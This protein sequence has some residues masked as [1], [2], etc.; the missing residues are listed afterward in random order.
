MEQ[1]KKKKKFR[2][3]LAVGLGLVVFTAV[4]FFVFGGP[5]PMTPDPTRGCRADTGKARKG[6]DRFFAYTHKK[7]VYI[8]H[9]HKK[10]RVR[11]KDAHKGSVKALA[12]SLDSKTMATAGG[13]NVI[14]LWD[15]G[16]LGNWVFR[17]PEKIAELTGNAY[18]VKAMAF[19]KDGKQLVVVGEDGETVDVWD[20]A[21]KQLLEN[22]LGLSAPAR[23][24]LLTVSFDNQGRVKDVGMEKA[25]LAYSK[26][27]LSGVERQGMDAPQILRDT[28]SGRKINT[29]EKA[30]TETWSSGGRYRGYADGDQVLI[31]KLC[32]NNKCRAEKKG[33]MTFLE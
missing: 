33:D 8:K 18:D 16:P 20:V 4:V 31:W 30:R 29:F 5:F 10:G 9:L 2:V 11:L 6:M 17:A 15:L 28:L 13:S 27:S 14:H 25:R 19:S 24:F 3:A 12:V 21:G 1:A 32:P 23:S 7:N 26:E 22:Q